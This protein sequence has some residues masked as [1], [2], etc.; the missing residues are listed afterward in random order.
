MIVTKISRTHRPGKR[1]TAAYCRVSTQRESQAESFETQRQS[2]ESQIRGNPDWCFA[3]VYSDRHSGTH[4]RNRPGFRAMMQDAENGKLDLILVK[5]IS[6]FSRNLVEC[7]NCVDR[8]S[9]LGVTVYF[10]KEHIFTDDPSSA[11]LLRL[12]AAVAQNESRSISQN[13]RM[14]YA[15]RSARGECHLGSNRLLGYDE[16]GGKLMPNQDAW[17]VK[18]VYSQFLQGKS[19]REI[20]NRIASLGGRT[21]RGKPCLSPGTIRYMLMNEAYMGDRILQKTLPKQDMTQRP[22][23]P[24]PPN[25]LQNDHPALIDRAAW[26]Q[27]QEI[28]RR[29]K[30]SK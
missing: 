30:K 18:E 9:A 8:L 28:L 6:R 29:R 7:Q 4:A 5:S 14:A 22:V 16:V 20:A 19:Y 3:G 27:V 13:V 24:Y 25:R 11:F 26:Q 17:I 2:Y 12:L 1:R 15:S 10:E 23:T 21:L